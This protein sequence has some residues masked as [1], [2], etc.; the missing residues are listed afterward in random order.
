M[1]ITVEINDQ[2]LHNAIEQQLS[3]AVAE[4]TNQLIARK[5]N[6]IVDKKLD[7]LTEARVEEL[8]EHAATNMLKSQ[9]SSNEWQR[10]SQIK[11]LVADA[12]VLIVKDSIKRQ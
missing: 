1:K 8:L 6:E 12:A 3:A 2:T 4:I 7:R 11:A 10:A 9:F 5:V